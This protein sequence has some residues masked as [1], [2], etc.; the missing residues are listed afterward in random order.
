MKTF[1]TLFLMFIFC[2]SVNAQAF[3]GSGDQKFQLGANLQDTG[4]GMV[5]SYDYGL[6]DI[7]SIGVTSTY[8]LGVEELIAVGFVDRF[9]AKARVNLHLG[10]TIGLS[11]NIDVYSGLNVSLKNLG[12]HAGARY[13]FSDSIGVFAEIGH[14][15][16]RYKSE[17]RSPAENLH[18][19]LVI[20]LGLSLSFL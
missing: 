4:A 16:A 3:D 17:N 5:L 11:D 6:N 10:S 9:D 12:I 20:N 7:I 8:V 2:C 15:L 14:P 19:Q 13:F 1:S 18:N